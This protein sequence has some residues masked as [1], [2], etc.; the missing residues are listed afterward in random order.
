LPPRQNLAALHER[1]V[2][3]DNYDRSS[4]ALAHSASGI[5]GQHGPHHLSHAKRVLDLLVA[6][7]TPGPRTPKLQR[8][9]AL[10]DAALRRRLN[11]KGLSDRCGD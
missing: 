6:R 5:V 4:H 3:V 2:L 10:P 11:S 8:D 7:P 1:G 9:P